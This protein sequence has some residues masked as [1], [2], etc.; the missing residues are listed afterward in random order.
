[1]ARKP[2][3][4]Q[5]IEPS[6]TQEEGS[7]VERFPRREG[8]LLINDRRLTPAESVERARDRQE[9]AKARELRRRK[10][11]EARVR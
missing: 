7:G 8:H 1:M 4:N 10:R 9:L 6:R 11:Q 2:S 5:A 3:R